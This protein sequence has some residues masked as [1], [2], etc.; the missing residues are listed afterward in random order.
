MAERRKPD[1][2]TVDNQAEDVEMLAGIH[3]GACPVVNRDVKSAHDVDVEDVVQD[4]FE[5]P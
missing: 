1:G 4:H 3:R 2:K 5:N